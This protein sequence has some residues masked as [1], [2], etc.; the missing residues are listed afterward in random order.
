MQRTKASVLKGLRR[1]AVPGGM[2]PTLWIVSFG[3]PEKRKK[4]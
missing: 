1:K 3:W 4:R 2:P